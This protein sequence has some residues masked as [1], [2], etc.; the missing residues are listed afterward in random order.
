MDAFESY[1]DFSVS[2]PWWRYSLI[3]VYIRVGVIF[4]MKKKNNW[5]TTYSSKPWFQ[6]RI[7]IWEVWRFCQDI[8]GASKWCAK[9]LFSNCMNHNKKGC[10]CIFKKYWI[11]Y[12]DESRIKK[13]WNFQCRGKDSNPKIVKSLLGA[14]YISHQPPLYSKN[15]N[16]SI[17]SFKMQDITG[18][19]GFNKLDLPIC[20]LVN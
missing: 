1:I 12:L 6:F 14:S 2:S 20:I 16:A 15:S 4:A 7:G 9:S 17:S 13:S 19:V 11:K 18:K 5:A 10:W 8:I 3:G